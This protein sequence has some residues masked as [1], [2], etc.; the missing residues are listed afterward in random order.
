MDLWYETTE[1]SETDVKNTMKSSEICRNLYK[2][3]NTDKE[4]E[5]LQ[6][7]VSRIF[8][9]NNEKIDPL[10]SNY[11]YKFHKITYE[12]I[13]NNP[14]WNSLSTKILQEEVIA[15][16]PYGSWRGFSTFVMKDLRDKYIMRVVCEVWADHILS[17][18]F[19][20]LWND[21]NYRPS[22]NKGG[23]ARTRDHYNSISNS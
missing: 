12:S 21:Y 19:V 8:K 11:N 6:E 13:R 3:F 10:Y 18:L 5:Y 23:Y 1:P 16:K 22:N 2:E 14:N 20:P 4:N 7:V 15:H 9:N 17:T